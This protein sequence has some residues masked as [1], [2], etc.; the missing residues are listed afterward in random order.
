MVSAL[1]PELEALARDL[2]T[3]LAALLLARPRTAPVL[4]HGDFSPDQVLVGDSEVRL[5]D[6]DR[7]GTGTVEA[8]LGSFAAAEEAVLPAVAGVVV[9]GSPSDGTPPDGGTPARAPASGAPAGG[10]PA[11]G[12][13]TALLAEGY[14]DAGG[15]FS[16]SAVDAWAAYRLFTSSVDPFRDRS[17]EWAA[18]MSWHL[19]RAKEL[20]P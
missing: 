7:A 13:K 9:G 8:D 6:F 4:V 10:A 5:I 17:P 18:D 2:E 11:G 1:L 20:I 15:R 19:S 12:P 16:Q 14:L 3:R